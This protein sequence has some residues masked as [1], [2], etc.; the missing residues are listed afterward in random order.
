MEASAVCVDGAGINQLG[1]GVPSQLGQASWLELRIDRRR[2]EKERHLGLRGGGAASC[3]CNIMR[4]LSARFADLHMPYSC[5]FSSRLQLAIAS[6]IDQGS[7]V[8]P[9]VASK[10]VVLP[11]IMIYI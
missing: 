11:A 7:S 2:I 6:T 4:S 3:N 9:A 10:L 5:L 1:V 8:S